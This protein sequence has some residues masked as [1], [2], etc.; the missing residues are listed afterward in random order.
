MGRHVNR[1]RV[2]AL[3]QANRIGFRTILP[4]DRQPRRAAQIV[5]ARGEN[6][7]LLSA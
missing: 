1:E 4:E 7:C 5:V 2:E 6:G 3:N